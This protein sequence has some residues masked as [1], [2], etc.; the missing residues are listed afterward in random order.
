MVEEALTEAGFGVSTAAR[1][2]DAIRMVENPNASFRALVTDIELRDK[3]STGWDVARRA[4]ELNPELPVVYLTGGETD[5]WVSH[6]VRN[7]ILV[8]K[9]FASDQVV[10][11]VL[12]LLNQRNTPGA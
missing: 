9:P 5:E 3:P 12:Q 2:K 1:A 8:S 10:E 7:S 11:A 6:G 4:R